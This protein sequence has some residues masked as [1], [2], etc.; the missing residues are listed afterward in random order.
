MTAARVTPRVTRPYY[1]ACARLADYLG[2]DVGSLALI[3]DG[4]F[5]SWMIF[6]PNHQREL[7]WTGMAKIQNPEWQA[8]WEW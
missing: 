8:K 6:L 7:P 5:Y 3:S 2:F 4:H 1:F